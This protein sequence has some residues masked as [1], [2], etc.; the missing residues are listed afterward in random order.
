MPIAICFF[1]LTRSLK[2]THQ[3]IQNNILNILQKRGM[4][5]HIYLHTFNLK[6]LTCRRS[7]ETKVKLD[8]HEWK[9][10]QPDAVQ[11]DSQEDFDRSMDY[12]V[13]MTHGDPWFTEGENVRN[14][15]RQLYSCQ[16]AFHMIRQPYQCYLFL[17]PDMKYTALDT[18][19]VWE[20]IHDQKSKVIYMPNQA[21]MNNVS[22]RF[23]FG[24][25][26][27]MQMVAPRLDKLLEY[28][29]KKPPHSETFLGDLIHQSQIVV[30]S[31]D[32]KAVRVRANGLHSQADIDCLEQQRDVI[33]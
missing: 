30:R 6:E 21:R 7:Q 17:R 26:T 31:L 27:T 25:E 20:I 2:W 23:Y 22:D 15:C 33:F 19:S 18:S 5:Y 32:M 24:N 1:G 3:S 9:L 11:I 12:D 4:K 16:S 14:L 10:L 8:E 29:T 28:A 13:I